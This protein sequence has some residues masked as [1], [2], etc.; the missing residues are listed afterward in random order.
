MSIDVVAE[1]KKKLVDSFIQIEVKSDDDFLKIKETLTRMGIV[2]NKSKKVWQ[3]CHI[4]HKAGKYYLVHFL[5]LFALDGRQVNIEEEDYAR[6][7]S[8][9]N[10]LEAWGLTKV[11]NRNVFKDITPISVGVIPFSKKSEYEFIQK[12]HIGRS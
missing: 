2:N 12:Y 8:I 9:A 7:Y 4:L 10:L 3:S 1:A 6:L 11:L 5:E